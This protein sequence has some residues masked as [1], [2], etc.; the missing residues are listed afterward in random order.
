MNS[1]Q[2][3]ILF[4]ISFEGFNNTFQLVKYLDRA[5]YP[6]DIGGILETLTA[7]KLIC[8]SGFANNGTP[9]EYVVTDKGK[10]ILRD[11]SLR[12][13]II[14]YIKTLQEPTFLLQLTEKLIA[15]ENV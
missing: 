13:E 10:E 12:V 7:E 8:V 3:L 15:R 4:L 6:A 9:I 1:R 14:N 5:D 11:K 2:K